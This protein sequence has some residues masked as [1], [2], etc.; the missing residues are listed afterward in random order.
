MLPFGWPLTAAGPA[1]HLLRYRYR[2]WNAPAA[3]PVLDTT[4]ALEEIASRHPGAPVVLVGHSMGGRAALWAAGAA[5]VTAVCALAPWLVGTD[6]VRLLTRAEYSRAIPSD[7][8]RGEPGYWLERG[9]AREAPVKTQC[10]I[11]RPRGFAAIPPGR[12]TVAGIAW[13]QPTGIG[14]VEVRMDGGPWRDAELSTEVNRSSWRMWRAHFDLGPGSHTVPSRATDRNGATQTEARAE[15]I[16]DGAS[17][18]PAT[19]FSVA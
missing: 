19:I 3:D 9:R 13:S 14:R 1:V 15:P 10:R 6:P 17:G 5:N 7:D 2:G 8:L 12:V 4:W 11:D 16:P 18:W